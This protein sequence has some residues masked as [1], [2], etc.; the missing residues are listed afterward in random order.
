MAPPKKQQR[1]QII[2]ATALYL[3]AF[4]HIAS[5][6]TLTVVTNRDSFVLV[7]KMI[8]RGAVLSAYRRRVVVALVVPLLLLSV[9]LDT[10]SSSSSSDAFV[11]TTPTTRTILR[12]SDNNDWNGQ[13][14]SNDQ[15]GR[16]RGC[17]LENTNGRLTEWIITIDG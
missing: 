10:S 15:S 7:Q 2:I 8:I 13:V 4:P 1:K 16:I 9:R 14:V 12:S 17:T 3:C 6:A 11:I 5:V